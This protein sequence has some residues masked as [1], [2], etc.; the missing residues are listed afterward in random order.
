MHRVFIGERMKMKSWWERVESGQEPPP[1]PVGTQE[2]Y[3]F[4]STAP[5]PPP[6]PPPQTVTM[7]AKEFG[8]TEEQFRAFVARLFTTGPP[9]RALPEK[10]GDDLMGPGQLTVWGDR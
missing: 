10:A 2:P 6:E 1:P 4:D 3:V 5:G 7:M 8:V 9:E